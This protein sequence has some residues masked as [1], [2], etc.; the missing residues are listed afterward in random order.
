MIIYE[1]VTICN[2]FAYRGKQEIKFGDGGNPINLIYGN[3]GFGKTSFIRALKLLFLGSGYLQSDGKVPEAIDRFVDRRKRGA[4]SPKILLKGYDTRTPWAGVL[5]TDAVDN[6]ENNFYIELHL[7]NNGDRY[8]IKRSWNI[9]PDVSEKLIYRNNDVGTEKNDHEAQN[10]I[11]A[12]IMPPNLIDFFIFDGEE[13]TELAENF[14]LLREKIKDMLNIT[15]L[16]K[17][18]ENGNKL[19]QEYRNEALKSQETGDDIKKLE[20]EIDNLQRNINTCNTAINNNK[21]TLDEK[22]NILE[23][24]KSELD[25]IKSGYIE[26]YAQITNN[27]NNATKNIEDSKAK[28]K[29]LSPSILFLGLDEL[30]D[31]LIDDTRNEVESKEMTIISQLPDLKEKISDGLAT[32]LHDKNNSFDVLA[33]QRKIESFIDEFVESRSANLDYI[34]VP[35]ISSL[36]T[37]LNLPRQNT[38]ELSSIIQLIKKETIAKKEYSKQ[39]DDNASM[40]EEAVEK[41]KKLDEEIKGLILEIKGLEDNTEAKKADIANSQNRIQE[42]STKIA[43][44]EKEI[45]V[46]ERIKKSKEI[47][48]NLV[49]IWEEYKRQRE[50][51]LLDQLRINIFDHY[52]QLTHKDEVARIDISDNF[53]ITMYKDDGSLI[54]ESGRSAGQ[55]QLVATSIFWALYELSEDRPLPLIID[56]PIARLDSSNRHRIATKYYSNISHQIIITPTDTEITRELYDSIKDKVDSVFQIQRDNNGKNPTIV[57]ANIDEILGENN[58]R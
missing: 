1:S 36:Q 22:N 44:L 50:Q 45:K 47:C 30:L 2:I 40:N 16:N 13:I 41:T 3:N 23:A 26:N 32:F 21:E 58:G 12:A 10:T 27:I 48:D 35:Q 57:K 54:G 56:T 29:D 15:A 55:K 7:I 39:A 42:N 20:S 25:S 11:N 4:L 19:K 53:E 49:Q 31:E 34:N 6:G 9:Y 52:K 28:L 37:V 46:G 24:K 38:K 8:T 14:K 33:T 51:K 43:R 18:I 17:L 5:N